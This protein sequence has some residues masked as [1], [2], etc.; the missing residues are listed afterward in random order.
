LP[1]PASGS[2]VE[3]MTAKSHLHLSKRQILAL[4]G[5]RLPQ[6]A[7]KMLRETGI[8]CD[9][10]VS[11]EYQDLARKYVIRGRESGGATAH[12]GAYCGFVDMNG[13]PLAWKPTAMKANARSPWTIHRIKFMRAS[14]LISIISMSSLELFARSN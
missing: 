12:I 9:P 5:I 6:S 1:D 8:Y 7:L 4:R 14:F 10:S 13:E 11:I 3:R 2:E